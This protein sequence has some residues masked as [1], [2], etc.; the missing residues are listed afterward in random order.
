M[1]RGCQSKVDT[2][3]RTNNASRLIGSLTY[4]DT[5]VGRISNKAL[6]SFNRSAAIVKFRV[7]ETLIVLYISNNSGPAPKRKVR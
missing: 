7:G 1:S 3:I 2:Y 4:Y 6:S 5:N